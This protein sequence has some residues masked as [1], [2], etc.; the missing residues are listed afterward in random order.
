[1]RRALPLTALVGAALAAAGCGAQRAQAPDTSSPL[2]PGG[3]VRMR[4]PA[5]GLTFAAPR[6]WSRLPGTAP[7]VAQ[8]TSG[9][10]SVT[11]WRYPRTEPLPRTTAGVR[12]ARTDLVAAA[13]A[14][15]P[16]FTTT[17]AR[18]GRVGTHP[19]IELRGTATVAGHQR[20]IHSVHVYA[21]GAELV[22][23]A[24]APAADAPRIDREVVEPLLRSLRVRAPRG[25]A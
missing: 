7:Q 8:L 19:A 22:V 21:F 23:D 6:A 11:L 25:A 13:K 18:I 15:T 16:D 14:R 5:E 20:S 4:L 12:Q 24:L 1:M 10:A 9:R 3:T 2:A 17:A